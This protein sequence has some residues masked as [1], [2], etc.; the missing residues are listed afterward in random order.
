MLFTLEEL[1]MIYT[2]TEYVSL[3]FYNNKDMINGDKYKVFSNQ[4]LDLIT[5]EETSPSDSVHP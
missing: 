1:Y 2:A 5:A 4:I 3:Y